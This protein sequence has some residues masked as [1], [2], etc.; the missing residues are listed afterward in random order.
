MGTFTIATGLG[1][2]FCGIVMMAV[3]GFGG[4]WVINKLKD[5]E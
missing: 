4:L 2:L 3:I 1:L 5:E